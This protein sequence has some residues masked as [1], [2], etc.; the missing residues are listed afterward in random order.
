MAPTNPITEDTKSEQS[1]KVGILSWF[2][3]NFWGLATIVLVTVVCAIIVQVFKK[4]GQMSVIESQAM[5]MN[6]MLPPKG[7]IPVGIA[8]VE[9]GAVE[10]SVTYTGTVQAYTDEDIYTRITGRVVSMPVYP[11]DRVRKGQLLVQL[12]PSDNSEYSAKKE[13]AASAEDAAMH[14]AGIAKDEFDQKRHEL[15]AAKNAEE[16]ARNAVDEVESS[17][18]YWRP[19]VERQKTLL[20][21]KVVSLAEYQKEASELKA[22][23]A[24]AQQARAKLREATSTRLAAQ[25]VFDA[26]IHHVGHFSSAARQAKAASKNAAIYEKYTRIV[27]QDDGVVTKRIISPGVVVNPGML[28]LKVAH[29]KNVRVQA[30]VASDDAQRLRLG[31]KVYIKGSEG[32]QAEVPASITAI[33]PAAD[34]ASRTFTVEALINNVLPEEGM[35]GPYRF[36]PGQYVVMRLLTGESEGLVIPSSAVVW[37]EGMSQVWKASSEKEYTSVKKYQCPMHPEVISDKPGTCPKCGMD[38]KRVFNGSAEKQSDVSAKKQYTCTMHPE[39]ISDKPGKCPKCGMDLVPKELGGRKVA[40][41]VDV[42][43]GLA[44][45]DKTEVLSGLSEGDE[46]IFAGFSRLQPGM[47]IVATEWGKSGPVRLPLASEVAGNRLDASNN[48]THEEMVGALMIKVSLSP[49]KSGS[50]FVV[51]KVDKHGGGTIPGAY[52]AVNTSMPGMNM[53]GSNLNGTT[54]LNGE[55]RL[56]GDLMSGLWQFKLSVTPPGQESAESTLDVEVP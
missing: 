54:G 33:F 24:R 22:A 56:K 29:V 17:L 1:R 11:G 45:A 5:D 36:L 25:A 49:A 46:V 18:S 26:A 31:N 48:W 39:V 2:T 50:N 43:I 8:I 52:V 19:E 14:N 40:Q 38:L 6:A 20:E 32:S 30:E 16:A 44:N 7:A 41:L 27:A 53:P 28:L 51:V 34:P 13:E 4:P 47:P 42:Q 12:D 21:S 35:A 23:Q 10:G 9:E 3:K 37:R 55:V 15:E